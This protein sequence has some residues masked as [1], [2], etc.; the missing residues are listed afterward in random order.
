M[1]KGRMDGFMD[2][3]N[4]ARDRSWAQ[5]CTELMRDSFARIQSAV[6]RDEN[7]RF[8]SE[9]I[10]DT[11]ALYRLTFHFRGGLGFGMRMQDNGE[12]VFFADERQLTAS[13]DILDFINAHE[14]CHALIQRHP[15]SDF[16][17][18]KTRILARAKECPNDPA[19]LA[20]KMRI[21]DEE[22]DRCHDFALRA[23]PDTDLEAFGQYL[24]F[25]APTEEEEEKAIEC[26]RLLEAKRLL[27]R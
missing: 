25:L 11:R 15:E 24:H 9:E 5:T 19:A 26:V 7:G 6:L 23:A 1:R 20:E 8:T 4:A 12:P 18:E 17:Q 27:L 2:S 22:E 21:H 16:M 3:G 13:S 14:L 10:E